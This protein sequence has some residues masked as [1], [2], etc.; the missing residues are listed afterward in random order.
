[1][2]RL[3]GWST[4]FSK[5]EGDGSEY[6]AEKEEKEAFIERMKAKYERYMKL[7]DKR[8]VKETA[9]VHQSINTSKEVIEDKG[10]FVNEDV[11]RLLFPGHIRSYYVSAEF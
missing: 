2:R 7:A 8:C 1:M 9:A 11:I 3:I 6:E 4:S 5:G 10:N